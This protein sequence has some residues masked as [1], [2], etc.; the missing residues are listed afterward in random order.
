MNTPGCPDPE[1]LGAFIDGT[2]PAAQMAAM[3]EHLATCD[4]CMEVMRTAA[5]FR[6]SEHVVVPI[7]SRRRQWLGALAAG[8]AIVFFA[9]AIAF[10]LQRTR[11][12]RDIAALID[13][14]PVS[15][16]RVEPR[17][18]GFRWAEL[19]RMR[20]DE[21][22]PR[23]SESLRLDGVAG[24]VLRRERADAHAAGVAELLI[25]Q[26]AAAI[27]KLRDAASRRPDDASVWND[28]AAA[29]YAEATQSRRADDLPLALA[30]AD[31]ALRI[32]PH[33][34]EA[35]FNRALVLERMQ[36]RDNAARAWRDFLAVDPSSAWA[37]EARRHLAG[38]GEL[39]SSDSEKTRKWFEVEGLG[40]WAEAVQRGDRVAAAARLA[41]AR[42]AASTL[43]DPLLG[44]AIAA[45]D[46]AGDRLASA[47]LAYRAARL[48]YR[49]H[50]LAAAENELLRAADA[51]DREQSPMAD[52]SRFYAASVLFD[53]NRIDDAR[54]MTNELLRRIA[55]SHV[56][57]AAEVRALRGR[58]E[59]Y[60]AHW[61]EAIDDFTVAA[62]A[63]KQLGETTNLALAE[64][65]LGDSYLGAGKRGEAWRH[66]VESFALL[67][68][69]RR[70][71]VIAAA[72]RGELRD[73]RRTAAEALLR[74]EIEE[75]E[76]LRNPLLIADAYK[77]RALLR[78]ENGED[79][80]DDLRLARS[81][82]ALEA[83]SGLKQSVES[84]C[85]VAEAV[86]TRQHD[87]RRSVALL[88]NAIAFRRKSGE[89]L[90]LANVLLESA[91][92]RRA[93]GDVAAA[94]DDY[95]AGLQEVAQQEDLDTRA[96]LK[97]E[98]V[99]ML[100]RRGDQAAAFEL[101]AHAPRVP[102]NTALIDYVL[103]PSGIAA[104]VVTSN[105]MRVALVPTDR[106]AL[107]ASIVAL[108]DAI[109]NRADIRREAATL[110][111]ILIAP[112]PEIASVPSLG[113]VADGELRDIPWAALYDEANHQFLVERH[114]I[115]IGTA[116]PAASSRGN[117]LLLVTN[118][119][120]GNLDLLDQLRVETSGIESLYPDHVAL[121]GNDATPQRFL[122]AANECD[123]IHFSGHAS[124]GALLM[125]GELQAGDLGR[126][127]L[128]RP[129]LAVLS[130]CS[131][132]TM[133]RAFVAAGVPRVVGTLW[134]VDD[135]RAAQLFAALH[136]RLRAGASPAAALRDAQL[137][138]LHAGANPADWAAAELLGG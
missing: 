73:G 114:D 56:A 134:A 88:A 76:R 43:R 122:R 77:R 7:A 37:A 109:Q 125:S 2:L 132:L 133:A 107:H 86:L 10:Y 25:E 113:I 84:D 8:I 35:L 95:A 71:A 55:P 24:D 30:A 23:D 72:A 17:I 135:A 57:L 131:T 115:T 104:F 111:K 6:E 11:P 127:T 38:L 59:L 60:A 94:R 108:R 34:G 64:A 80:F 1:T 39:H 33:N 12:H 19:R 85:E 40:R 13:A 65:A 47:H 136:R 137:E 124:S 46:R 53:E 130:A 29:Y 51:F 31:H 105:G 36:L 69:D 82:L 42:A 93:M 74:V 61:S 129:R 67:S 20:A 102:A 87:A 45:I 48:R 117:R 78:A 96:S 90:A 28:L 75:A 91:R 15:Y 126:A 66:R 54:S 121:G 70:I 112:L 106:G 128:T 18:S 52:V 9:G 92:S 49:D 32:E 100:L 119:S 79:G 63:F 50:D 98:A 4:D 83:D 3:N 22:V 41:E 21:G 62:N 97:G 120:R 16:R 5:S 110:H 68:S 14:A 89:H 103:V 118:D 26:P 116:S 81:A 58:C 138:L 99:E 101:V 27:E 44:D 123:V